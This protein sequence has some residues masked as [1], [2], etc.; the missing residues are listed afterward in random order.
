MG[1]KVNN[2][3]GKKERTRNEKEDK[4]IN[5]YTTI[6]YLIYFVVLY[7]LYRNDE[8]ILLNVKWWYYLIIYLFISF[9]IYLILNIPIIKR[10]IASFDHRTVNILVSFV[11]SFFISILCN[12]GLKYLVNDFATESAIREN[13]EILEIKKGRYRRGGD[14]YNLKI[15]FRDEVEKLDLNKDL[16]QQL[17]TI[18]LTKNHAIIKV[19]PSIFNIYIVENVLIESKNIP[20]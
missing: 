1:G 6:I 19:K 11:L 8:I 9:L 14:Y 13:C 5:R 17:E 16:Y 20:K 18:S 2:S 10:K 4:K 12:F 7:L 3:I 15:N